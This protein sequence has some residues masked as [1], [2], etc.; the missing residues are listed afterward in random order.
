MFDCFV[1]LI[2][3]QL[4]I[5][6]FAE[7]N[8]EEDFFGDIPFEIF[9][10]L[11]I[12]VQQVTYFKRG[13]MVRNHIIDPLIRWERVCGLLFFPLINCQEIALIRSEF[14]RLYC[15]ELK[16]IFIGILF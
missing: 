6:I 12:Q 9:R 2:Y 8:V 3:Y 7:I 4:L 15:V 1:Y 13:T 5:A 14:M 11:E 10:D 16:Y